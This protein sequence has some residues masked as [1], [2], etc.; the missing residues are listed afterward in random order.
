[1]KAIICNQFGLP[2]SLEYLDVPDPV[3]GEKEVLVQVKAC[4]VN[5]P[6]TLII[7][8]KYQFKPPFPFSPGS[9]VAGVVEAVGAKVKHFKPGDEVFGIKAYGGFAEKIALD[10]RMCIPKPPEMPFEKAASFLFAY[11]TSLYALQNRGQLQKGETV[12]ILGASG[13]VG[14]T[15]VEL[16]KQMGATVIAAA[17][18]TEKLALCKQYGAD[19]LINYQEEDLKSKLKE[20]TDGK[21]VDIVYDPVGGPYTEPALRG[22]AWNGRYLVIGFAAGEIPKIPLNLPLLKGCQIV[23]VFFGAFAQKNPMGLM[24]LLGQLMQ[25]FQ[26]NQLQP[27]IQQTFPLE[28]APKALEMMMERKVMGKLVVTV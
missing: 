13:G 5:F 20:I 8:G 28:E 14:L 6:D 11:G 24:E 16:V 18:T 27:H 17:S 10:G 21:G 9:D 1:M 3:P 4:S 25:F 22:M 2:N 23:G 7:Q 26:A 15:A 12:L 19:Y